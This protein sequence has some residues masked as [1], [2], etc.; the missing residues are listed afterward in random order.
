MKYKIVAFPTGATGA[1]IAAAP[2]VVVADAERGGPC[3]HCL[4]DSLHGERLALGPYSPFDEAGA[5]RESGPIFIHADG[6]VRF[7]GNTLPQDYLPRR[8]VLRAYD[9]RDWIDAAKVAEPGEFDGVA[10]ELLSDPA[11]DY[12]H[13]RHLAYGCYAFRLEREPT[14][15]S[16]LG[17]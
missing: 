12:V 8:L 17:S 3:R 9:E 1:F 16:S 13:V 7:E 5:Y 14:Y 4:Q 6:C 10:R 11:V 15:D 2:A